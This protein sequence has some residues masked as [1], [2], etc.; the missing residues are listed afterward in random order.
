M[1]VL[2]VRECSD[3]VVKF[4]QEMGIPCNSRAVLH[5]KFGSFGTGVLHTRIL[6]R[7]IQLYEEGN[8]PETI[9]A[10]TLALLRM[11]Q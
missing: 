7:S 5:E 11:N 4:S 1:F 8:T 9:A 10:V 2:N 3:V 6:H